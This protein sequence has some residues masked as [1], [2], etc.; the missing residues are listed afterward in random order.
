MCQ[1]TGGDLAR[2]SFCT[3]MRDVANH[4]HSSGETFL[5]GNGHVCTKIIFPVILE[6]IRL[7]RL[8]VIG[9][10]HSEENSYSVEC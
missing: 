9:H 2:V 8:I 1:S 4:I 10:S 3:Q 6:Q 5:K 7:L